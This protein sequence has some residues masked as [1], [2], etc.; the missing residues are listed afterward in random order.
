MNNYLLSETIYECC[1]PVSSFS[2]THSVKRVMHLLE[3][4]TPFS[5]P[6]IAI[7]VLPFFFVLWCK[8]KGTVKK[9]CDDD[10]D[11]GGDNEAKHDSDD[12]FCMKASM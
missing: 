10:D 6:L 5:L 7:I 8:T 12:R 3:G 11:D 9:E 4:V 1:P 2:F